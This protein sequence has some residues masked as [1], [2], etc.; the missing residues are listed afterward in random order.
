M[1]L[2]IDGTN[3]ISF[4]NGVTQ[5]SKAITAAPQFKSYYNEYPTGTVLV[6]N[7]PTTVSF[8]RI[9]IADVNDISRSVYDGSIQSTST[10]R[11][12]FPTAGYYKINAGVGISTPD[13][14][15]S[16]RIAIYNFYV[17]LN[18]TRNENLGRLTAATATS[19]FGIIQRNCSVIHYF[20]ANGYLELY[21]TAAAYSSSGASTYT[22]AYLA[23]VSAYLI[24]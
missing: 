15:T 11:I 23:T 1:A 9:P 20:P 4:R 10:T 22:Y 3:G 17:N 14:S 18:G 8:N 16:N 24:N 12:T 2:K 13:T 21:A 19:E 5:S 6:F 7:N